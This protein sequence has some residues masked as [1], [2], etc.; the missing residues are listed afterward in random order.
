MMMDRWF[1]IFKV[2]SILLALPTAAFSANYAWQ[3]PAGA[4]VDPSAFFSVH[5]YVDA[6]YASFS[7]DWTQTDPAGLNGPG[8]L[9]IP[10]TPNASFQYDAALIFASEISKESCFKLEKT[11]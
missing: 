11:I 1:K 5:G 4:Y 6:V 2:V 3:S 8:N 9:L 10:N 7:R